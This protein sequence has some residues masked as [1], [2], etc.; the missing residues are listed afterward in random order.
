MGTLLENSGDRKERYVAKDH[1]R[2]GGVLSWVAGPS[3]SS[4]YTSQGPAH[5]PVFR[6]AGL[7][8]RLA[9]GAGELLC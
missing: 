1:L 6:R 5:R 2:G 4:L 9:L 7:E 8:D 3:A